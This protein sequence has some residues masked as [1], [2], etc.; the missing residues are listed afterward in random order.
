MPDEGITLRGTSFK[1]SA[2]EKRSTGQ[3]ENIQTHAAIEGE[4]PAPDSEL[5]SETRSRVR[6]EL[7]TLHHD[8]RK[9]VVAA[10]NKRVEDQRTVSE[11]GTIIPVGDA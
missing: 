11:D 3:Y 7:L 1:V 5:D 8:L 10:A 6:A 2:T 9:V 4:L